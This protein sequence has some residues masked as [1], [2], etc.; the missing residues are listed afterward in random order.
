MRN[1]VETIL[2]L[3]RKIL[4]YVKKRMDNEDYKLIEIYCKHIMEC[5]ENEKQDIDEIF[6]AFENVLDRRLGLT[7]Y[8]E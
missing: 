1:N 3:T 4:E 2:K 8:K 5:C 7:E 6:G